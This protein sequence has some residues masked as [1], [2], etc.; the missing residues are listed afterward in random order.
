MEDL[1][2]ELQ[3]KRAERLA[4]LNAGEGTGSSDM[5]SVAPSLPEDDRRS[6]SSLQSEGFV[7][8][9]QLGES[10]LEGEGAAQP[11][12]NKTQLWNEVKITCMPPIPDDAQCAAGRTGQGTGN[13]A[14]ID[15]DKLQQLRAP[16]LSS[17][18]SLC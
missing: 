7:R 10:T 16:L 9:S 5:S 11:K 17:T 8:A 2:K 14:R 12:R 6:L 4:R 3:K 15:A 18:P 13:G 1:T